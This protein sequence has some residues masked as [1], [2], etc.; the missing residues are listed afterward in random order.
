MSIGVFSRSSL[1]SIKALRSY[2]DLGLL[3]PAEVDPSSGYRSYRVSQLV[4]AAVIKRLR[5]LDVPLRDIAEVVSARDPEVTRDVLARHT[6]AMTE[7][8]VETERIVKELHVAVDQPSLATPVHVRDIPPAHALAISGTVEREA[9]GAFLDLAY[10]QLFAA[11][12]ALDAVMAGPT[13]ASYP[14]MIEDDINAVQAFIPIAE[15]VVVT[16]ALAAKG[17]NVVL[18]P[19]ATCAVATHA[20]SYETIG[21]TYRQLGAWVARNRVSAE[22]P[23]REHYV[24]SL[25]PQSG[26]LF[27]P[28]EFRTEI[29]W[30]VIN[31]PATHLDA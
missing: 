26:E 27:P 10:P 2:H 16:D 21:E 9:Y 23:V 25:N 12:E 15:P 14:P 8:L 29:C 13:G 6:A 30:P 11:L 24:V 20:G 19:A 7:R 5:E 4:D 3:I 18:L 1:V 31:D 28:D 17:L 22:M